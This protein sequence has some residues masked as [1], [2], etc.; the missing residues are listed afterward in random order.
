LAAVLTCG[1]V[2]HDIACAGS[3]QAGIADFLTGSE[4]AD[5][6]QSSRQLRHSST[7]LVEHLRARSRGLPREEPH[8]AWSLARRGRL[9]TTRRLAS[10]R[11]RRRMSFRARA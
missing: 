8:D 3:L 1:R 9:R 5:A 2:H 10:L 4:S 6:P 11:G 7:R